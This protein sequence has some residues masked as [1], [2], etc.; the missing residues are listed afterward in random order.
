MFVPAC[1]HRGERAEGHCPMSSINCHRCAGLM[2]SSLPVCPH[3]G[4]PQGEA[5]RAESAGTQRD[6]L[7]AVVPAIL[8]TVGG[9]FVIGS[10]WGAVGGLFIGLLVGVAFVAARYARQSRH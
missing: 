1:R 4:A 5:A 8:G 7:L 6:I 9:W 2:A 10:E 3:C